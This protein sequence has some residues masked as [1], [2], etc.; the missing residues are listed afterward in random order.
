M[1]FPPSLRTLM[2]VKILYSRV[3]GNVVNRMINDDELIVKLENV[4][5]YGVNLQ[6]NS[7]LEHPYMLI[8]MT[9]LFGVFVWYNYD[10]I[11][12]E[13]RDLHKLEKLPMF[14]NIGI[15]TKAVNIFFIMFMM[16]FMKNIESAM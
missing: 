14:K 10:M 1:L 16:I 9:L 2:G 6:N 7:F 8:N 4:N 12:Q 11:F 15:Y 13:H 5:D 3:M